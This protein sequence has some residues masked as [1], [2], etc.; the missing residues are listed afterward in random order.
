MVVFLSEMMTNEFG[1][2]IKKIFILS[3]VF[4]ES[5]VLNKRF[6]QK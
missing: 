1:G 2:V 5:F 6:V 4:I 3:F